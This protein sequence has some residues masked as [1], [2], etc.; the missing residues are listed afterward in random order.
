MS[1]KLPKLEELAEQQH[2]CVL[3]LLEKLDVKAAG[4]AGWERRIMIFLNE[5]DQQA[6]Y[7]GNQ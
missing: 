3:N 6:L 2:K 1:L 5:L 7:E 4:N